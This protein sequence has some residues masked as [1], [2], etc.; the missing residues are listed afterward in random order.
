MDEFDPIA[1]GVVE[2]IRNDGYACASVHGREKP[3]PTI[4]LLHKARLLL[5][6]REDGINVY[7]MLRIF[8]VQ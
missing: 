6:P 2:R 4:V 8:F 3:G 5:R 7:A 1:E